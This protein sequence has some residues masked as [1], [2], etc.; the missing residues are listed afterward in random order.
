[1]GFWRSN[2]FINSNAY[3]NSGWRA[4]A[5]K[6]GFSHIEGALGNIYFKVLG[7]VTADSAITFTNAMRNSFSLESCLQG[8]FAKA[9]NVRTPGT[10]SAW[11]YSSGDNLGAI[12]FSW[13]QIQWQQGYGAELCSI[14]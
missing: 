12:S 10:Y 5:S 2:K 4:A 13:V 14:L 7:S 8:Q 6:A 9:K 11:Y 3:F 1:M